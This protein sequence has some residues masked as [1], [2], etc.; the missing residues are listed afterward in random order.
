[1]NFS[2]D[3]WSASWWAHVAAGAEFNP[4]YF[5]WS[6]YDGTTLKISLVGNDQESVTV[7]IN[8]V[9][10]N[11]PAYVVDGWNHFVLINRIDG[12]TNLFINGK[13]LGGTVTLG[14]QPAMALPN[15]YLGGNRLTSAYDEKID[16][17]GWWNCALTDNE[18]AELY[19][20]GN[21]WEYT[22]SD[23]I[24]EVTYSIQNINQ[25]NTTIN[26]GNVV[27][28][29]GGKGSMNLIIKT[30]SSNSPQLNITEIQDKYDEKF[31]NNTYYWNGVTG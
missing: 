13:D 26:N 12:A 19:N 8:G 10:I 2:G 18:V 31:N 4:G 24:S 30:L 29:C 15:F 6:I 5:M 25:I 11:I 20:S 23:N 1:M 16:A 9:A 21:G 7:R 27:V 14:P 28:N 3:G 22:P 17:F